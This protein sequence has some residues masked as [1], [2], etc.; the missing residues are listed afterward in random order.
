MLK[1]WM[2]GSA[3]ATN[4]MLFEKAG[5]GTEGGGGAPDGTKSAEM[6]AL[7]AIAKQV[8]GFKTMLGE[9]AKEEDFKKVTDELKKLQ[10]G[11]ETLTAKEVERQIK[12][13]NTANE[14]IHKQIIEMQEELAK[15]K[16]DGDSSPKGPVQ[17]IKRADVEA[18]VKSIYPDGKNGD[19]KKFSDAKIEIKAAE[20]FSDAVT[21]ASGADATAFTGRFIDPTLY[22]R[23]RKTNII[24]DYMNIQTIDVPT[25]IYLRKIE[26][27][28]GTAP[29]NDPG[30]AAWILC[31][32]PKPKRSFRVTTGEVDAKKVAIFGEIEDCLLQDVPSME[33]WIREDFMDEMNEAINDGLLN[34][35]PSVNALAPLG[36]KTNAIQYTATAEYDETIVDP[37]YIDMIIALAALFADNKESLDYV[38]VTSGVYFR[39][40]HLKA[41]DG[42]WLNNQLVYVNSAG[43]LVIAGVRVVPVDSDDVPNT[44]VLAVGVDLGFKIYAYGNMVFESG[45]NGENFREDKTS[46][47]AY[48]RFL[49]FIPEERENSVLYDTWANIEAAITAPA[50]VE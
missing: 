23:R 37:N 7:E 30:G 12:A 2:N 20:T 10:E 49:S 43:I 18:F 32:S 16:D 9:K 34:N 1:H 45:L 6:L 36:L 40:L 25:L 31:G 41:T 46:Y 35:N 19:K 11:L 13:I 39:M 27:G 5:D 33:R 4:L 29:D 42:K 15:K 14:N 38:M 47:R 44:H 24:L 48:Q 17:L 50:P 21:F 8:Y 26:V 28:T 22:Q 3:F